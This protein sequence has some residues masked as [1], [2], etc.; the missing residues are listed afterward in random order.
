MA[1]PW[2]RFQTTN[3]PTPPAGKPWERFASPQANAAPE[4]PPDNADTGLMSALGTIGGDVVKTLGDAYKNNIDPYTGA[5]IR[6]GVSALQEGKDPLQAMQN[7]FGNVAS[8]DIGGKAQLARAGVSTKT[9]SEFAPG[10]F[11]DKPQS[12][13]FGTINPPGLQKGGLFDVS[14]AGVGGA[15]LE[16]PQDPLSWASPMASAI[17]KTEEGAGLL[18]KGANVALNPVENLTQPIG[19]SIYK[20]GLKRVDQEAAKFGKEPVSDLLMEKGIS[21]NARQIQ[22]QMNTLGEQLLAERNQLLKE[23]TKKGGDVSMK[24]AMGPAQARIQEIRLSKNPALQPIADALE[25][26]VQ[27]YMVLDAKGETPNLRTLPVQSEFVPEHQDVKITPSSQ[28]VRTLPVQAERD[29]LSPTQFKTQKPQAV[30]EQVPGKTEPGL[31]KPDQY[32]QRPEQMVY[33][34]TPAKS[35]PTPLQAT[36]YKSSIQ[37]PQN[38]YAVDKGVANAYR[39]ADKA[40]K[41]GLKTAVESSV[42]KTLGADKAAELKDLNDKL[43][44][45]LTTKQKQLL[46]ASK[47]EN[48]N[49]LTSVDAPLM[50]LGGHNAAIAKKLADAAKLTGVRTGLGKKM[51]QAGGLLKEH[52]NG[53]LD[54]AIRQT[55]FQNRRKDQ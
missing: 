23:A 3:T 9:A 37:I 14:P 44:R 47:E 40:V 8:E 25:S 1:K 45:I 20:S 5:P 49:L 27:K 55:L 46:E 54:P 52:A 21:G 51:Y 6:A 50:V 26:D 31:L 30:I 2:E 15:L 36:G 7:Q 32:N 24:E 53:L 11:Q 43:G 17:G 4:P 38:A 10:Y 12:S 18:A 28:Q 41:G 42:G 19:K 35:G 39:G 16:I 34:T 48:K 13:K 33:D 29:V 22:E